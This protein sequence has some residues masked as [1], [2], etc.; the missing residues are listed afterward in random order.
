MKLLEVSIGYLQTIC[1]MK[2][3]SNAGIILIST[4][5]QDKAILIIL[6]IEPLNL[7]SSPTSPPTLQTN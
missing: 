5:Y 3:S 4:R 7:H 1:A 6:A 2:Y